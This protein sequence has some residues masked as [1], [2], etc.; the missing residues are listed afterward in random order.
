VDQKV[1]PT[2]NWPHYATLTTGLRSYFDDLA[3]IIYCELEFA[4]VNSYALKGYYWL[5]YNWIYFCWFISQAQT[6]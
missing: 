1:K 6:N 2:A 5:K 3:Y 4:W